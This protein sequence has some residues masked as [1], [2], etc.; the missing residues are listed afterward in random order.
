MLRCRP[1]AAPKHLLRVGPL[2][3]GGA[4]SHW[5]SSVLNRGAKAYNKC[6]AIY[7]AHMGLSDEPSRQIRE[8]KVRSVVSPRVRLT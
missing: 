3:G 1:I 2:R 5:Q 4:A 6:L 8:T 7:G